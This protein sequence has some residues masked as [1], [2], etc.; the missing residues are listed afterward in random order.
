MSL[1]ELFLIVAVVAALAC[2]AHMLWRARRGEKACCVPGEG[3]RQ[4]SLAR[5]QQALARRVEELGVRR[6]GEA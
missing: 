4:E 1:S 3:P 5:R 2:P 6:G